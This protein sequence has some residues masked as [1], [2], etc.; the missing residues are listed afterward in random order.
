M[1]LPA[2]GIEGER[3]IVTQGS[4]LALHSVSHILGAQEML[5]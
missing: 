5:L 4:D 3:S 1:S 2:D